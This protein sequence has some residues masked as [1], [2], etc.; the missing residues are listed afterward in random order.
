MRLF[1]LLLLEFN[2]IKV[3]YRNR[4]H[5]A[6]MTPKLEVMDDVSNLLRLSK[7][8]LQDTVYRFILG[9]AYNEVFCFVTLA[10]Y[11]LLRT[12]FPVS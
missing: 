6:F 3:I 4:F 11:S 7:Y 5:I 10:L 2:C 12:C 9:F 1:A 8:H